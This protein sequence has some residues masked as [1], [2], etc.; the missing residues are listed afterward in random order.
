MSSPVTKNNTLVEVNFSAMRKRAGATAPARWSPQPAP[1]TL[2]QPNWRDS[3]KLFLQV[4]NTSH[5]P[6]SITTLAEGRYLE[7]NPTFLSLLGY[8]REQVVGRTS[9]GLGIWKNRAQRTEMV[10]RLQNEE[11]VRDFETAIRGA[12]NQIL[13]WISSAD[14]IDVDGVR[15]ILVISDDITEQRHAEERL[16]NVSARLIRAQEEE[17]NRI[18][19]ELHDSLNQKLALLCVDLEEFS[20]THQ[21]LDVSQEL[22][23]MCLRLQ[24]AS[25]D[26]HGLSQQLHPPKLDYLGLIPALR[27]LCQELSARRELRITLISDEDKAN[28]D[29]LDKELE[30]CIYRVV[31]EALSNVI[32]HSAACVARVY[33]RRRDDVLYVL[34][35]DAGKGFNVEVAR[36]KGRLGLIS[37][38]E[39]LRLANGRLIIRSKPHRGTQIEARI[40]LAK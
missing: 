7:A 19:R 29:R 39:R 33:I 1:T 21:D 8:T 5:Q 30:L 6:M 2:E 37:M 10:T 11:P 4:F 18:A 24:D 38:E 15:C 31:Q 13:I 36:L 25:D 12:N 3:E 20:K 35:S 32:K 16:R 17:R 23:A 27:D 14:L 9:L 34:I 22:H 40:P 28:L 26:V